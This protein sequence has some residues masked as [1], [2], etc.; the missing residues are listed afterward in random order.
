[1]ESKRKAL[2]RRRNKI[3]EKV[4]IKKITKNSNINGNH[5]K[6]IKQVIIKI[7]SKSSSEE[8]SFG[9]AFRKSREVELIKLESKVIEKFISKEL[10]RRKK[11]L[12]GHPR[13]WR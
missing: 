5:R 13:G 4:V 3:K 8:R 9:K 6:I 1:M 10:I 2:L 11:V 7:T 12:P